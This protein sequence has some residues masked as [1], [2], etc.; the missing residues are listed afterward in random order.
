MHEATI[1]QNVIDSVCQLIDT[2]TITGRLSAVVLKVGKLTAVVPEHLQFMFGVL[3]EDGP[4]RGVRL[5]IEE[6]PIRVRCAVCGNEAEI[7]EVNFIC[8][9]CGS[10]EIAILSGRELIVDAVEVE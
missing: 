3:A 4:L 1:A 9:R 5:Q 7:E 6:V 2:G 10:V 8:S